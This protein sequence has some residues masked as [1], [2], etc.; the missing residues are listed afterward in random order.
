M[1]NVSPAVMTV[2]GWFDA[3]D[4]YG[5]LHTYEAIEKQNSPSVK[6]FLV[7]GPW[8]HGQWAF[9]KG[10]NLGNIYWGLDANKKFQAQEK[11]FFDYYLKGA[12]SFDI[13]EQP[14][15][16]QGR[17]NGGALIT[18][19][20]KILIEKIF[21]FNLPVLFHLWLLFRKQF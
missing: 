1:K 7:M 17:M 6:N 3:E 14:Y 2:G 9:G 12:G 21:T 15:L 16:L 18:G 20:L 8:S 19:P 11:D 4:L 13:P 5:A 10:N